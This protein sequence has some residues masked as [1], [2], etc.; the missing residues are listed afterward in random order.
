MIAATPRLAN[1][2]GETRLERWLARNRFAGLAARYGLSAAGPISVSLAHFIASILLL[3]ALPPAEFGLFS[4]L[5]VIVPF[6]VSATG[7]L[8]GASV[9]TSLARWVA[10]DGPEL[11]THMKMSLVVAALAFVLVSALM[12]WNGAP[13]E[14]AA[15]LGLFAA[16]MTLRWFGRS[17]AFA[18]Q[19]PGRAVLCDVVYATLALAGLGA[20]ALT[21]R[22][23][24]VSAGAVLLGA[25]A[26]A[27]TVFGTSYLRRQAWPGK[28]GSL[29]AYK[30]IWL[31]LTRWSLM[32]VVLTELTANA[33]A[34]V[35]TFLSGPASFALLALGAL[36]MR[37]VSLVLTAFP[38]RERPLM[39]R[40]LE[41]GDTAGALRCVK[42]FRTAA[43]A[44]WLGTVALAAAILTMAPQ[45]L[46]KNGYAFDQ[47]AVVTGL[48]ALIMAVRTWRTPEAT[49]LQAAR[50]FRPLARASL[51]S[52]IASLGA[53]L[54]L[55]L[56][57]G[58][59]WSLAGILAGDLVMMLN[60]RV[61]ARQWRAAHA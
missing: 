6:C 3:H 41:A 25:S 42:E 57:F 2:K 39:V 35:V 37:P 29:S 58:P 54:G 51:Y 44:I 60:I 59:V 22:I 14:G 1:Y 8:L 12:G 33:H 19:L 5:L 11:A 13:L 61:L 27:L 47:L 18:L 16:A 17:L 49:L 9:T 53:T 31:D 32:G 45:L 7:A 56:A 52:S 43:G 50:Q 30:A 10:V 21:D 23:T 48:W 15:L 34:Y 24:L 28:G 20:L 26:C 55:L 40:R 46:L 36:L 4:F 38:D